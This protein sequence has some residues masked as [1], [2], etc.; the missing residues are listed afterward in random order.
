MTMLV[1]TLLLGAAGVW[2]VAD[3]WR[4]RRTRPLERALA[5]HPVGLTDQRGAAPRW[6]VDRCTARPTDL[7][8]V[9]RTAGQHRR[10]QIVAAVTGSVVAGT[11]ASLIGHGPTGVLTCVGFAIAGGVLGVQHHLRRTAAGQ[12]DLIAGQ[13]VDLAEFLAV[14]ATAGLSASES[15]A[16]AGGHVAEPLASWVRG[17][18][19]QIRG[20]ETL[21][22]AVS[23][24]VAALDVAE[25]ARVMGTVV[26][27]TERGSPLAATLAAQSEDTRARLRARALERAGRLEA[28]M[29]IPIV[30]LV[31]PSIVVVAV[32]PGLVTLTSL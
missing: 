13:T 26:A 23:T 21:R 15:L 11:W 1:L 30:F 12:R 4:S 22:R 31:L 27:A 3:A 2:L 20:G 19:A 9:S 17:I 32:Y 18:S 5:H 24:A 29:L 28:V 6:I 7:T 14:C 25:F 16:H 10:R 8:L